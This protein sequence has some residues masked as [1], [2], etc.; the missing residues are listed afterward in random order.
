M[1]MWEGYHT[2]NKIPVIV[3]VE[4]D[5]ESEKYV[6]EVVRG[7]DS[8]VKKFKAKHLPDEGLMHV[9]DMEKSIKLANV[10]IKERHLLL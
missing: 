2:D 5:S 3:T 1:V 9:S 10:L 4:Y 6:V 8:D 7:L